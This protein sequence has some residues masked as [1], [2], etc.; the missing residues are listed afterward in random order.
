MQVLE[1]NQ[2]APDPS[3]IY[4]RRNYAAVARI[5][6]LSKILDIKISFTIET[7]PLGDKMLYVDI[8]PGEDIDYPIIPIKSAI[9]TFILNLDNEGKLP[10]P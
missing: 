3:F 10:C 5:Q 2:I 8:A 6:L 1:L 7:G 9:K 4:Y